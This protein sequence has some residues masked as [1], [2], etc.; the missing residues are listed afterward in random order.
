MGKYQVADIKFQFNYKFDEYFKN[1][2]EAYSIDESSIV[3]HQINVN[4][5]DDIPIPSGKKIGNQNPYVI[6]NHDSR[7][8]YFKKSDKI[9]ILM[10]HDYEYKNIEILLNQKRVKNLPLTEYIATGIMF[11]EL[12]MHLGNLPIHATAISINNEAV[13]FSA[14]SGTGK[15][16][17]ANYWKKIF[18]E[19]IFINDDKPLIKIK[20]NELYVY[21]S[22]FSGEHRINSNLEAKLKAIVLLRRGSDNKIEVANVKEVIPEL[23]KNTLNP[24]LETSW[25]KTFPIFEK[26][27]Q[28]I[29]VLKLY[30]TNSEEAVKKIYDYL[31]S[32]NQ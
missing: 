6:T 2:I 1:N 24:K 22:P 27:Y 31:F 23:I 12:S 25:E 28:E 32:P 16:T 10:K 17:H 3:N 15:S 11:L 5:I 7:I 29:P 21:G 14:P 9:T 30:A 19:A 13:L 20:D 18:P 26:I 8:I 4:L